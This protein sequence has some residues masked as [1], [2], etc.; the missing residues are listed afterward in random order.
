MVSSAASVSSRGSF[1]H[2]AVPSLQLASSHGS[3]AKDGNS[4]T[5]NE[6]SGVIAYPSGSSVVFC[7]VPTDSGQDGDFE[8]HQSTHVISSERSIRSLSISPC[9]QFLAVGEL[10]LH[11]PDI[12][13][14]D[15]S[16]MQDISLK[17]RLSGA[18]NFAVNCLRWLPTSAKLVSVGSENT[19]VLWCAKSKTKLATASLARIVKC[20]AVSPSGDAVIACGSAGSARIFELRRARGILEHRPFPFIT[21]EAITCC[22]WENFIFQSTASG[23]IFICSSTCVIRTV[24]LGRPVLWISVLG[25]EI[26]C[27]MAGGSCRV[28]DTLNFQARR[29][30]SPH[31]DGE[32]ADCVAVVANIFWTLYDDGSQ[33][34]WRN[35]GSNKFIFG[36]LTRV[37][38]AVVIGTRFVT[39]SEE[40]LTLWE[41]SGEMVASVPQVFTCAVVVDESRLA[42]GTKGGVLVLLEIC[43]GE[44]VKVMESDKLQSEIT[45]IA[46]CEFLGERIFAC[47]T[48]SKGIK[49]VGGDL[50]LKISLPEKMHASQVT[51]LALLHND[52]GLRLVTCSL[53]K[54]IIISSIDISKSSFTILKKFPSSFRWLGLTACRESCIALCGDNS[55]HEIDPRLCEVEE[56]MKLEG[57]LDTDNAVVAQLSREVIAVSQGGKTFSLVDL[58]AKALVAKSPCHAEG[59]ISIFPTLHGIASASSDGV[60]SFWHSPMKLTPRHNV[61]DNVNVDRRKK[62]R[63][64]V[65]MLPKWATTSDDESIILDDKENKPAGNWSRVSKVGGVVRSAEDIRAF[66]ERMSLVSSIDTPNLA[67]GAI[68]ALEEVKR[69]YPSLAIDSIDD[70]AEIASLERLRKSADGISTWLRDA[71]YVPHPKLS[72]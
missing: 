15:L 33:I 42:V 2:T 45:N 51:G 5:F 11:K 29:D 1:S 24:N 64:S 13:V 32:S 41:A 60:I 21:K 16:N 44:V 69:S 61:H 38:Q 20:I 58:H 18:H 67:D 37:K 7:N 28:L 31:A 46:F 19:L 72:S 25:D 50:Q 34:F 70:P 22:L 6:N 23:S 10:G 40:N 52:A 53:D 3:S 68:A 43:N 59:V 4:I 48:K 66:E 30:V 55:I 9:G 26:S 63:L 27:A 47:V 56:L 14:Y 62:R 12:L 17:Y 57:S 39:I 35:A 8:L 54:F 65:A 49:I 71:L 36:S